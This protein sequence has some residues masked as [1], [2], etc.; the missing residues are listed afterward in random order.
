MKRLILTVLLISIS[1]TTNALALEVPSRPKGRISDYTKTLKTK[2]IQELEQTLARYE[3]ETTNQIAV[4]LIPTLAGDNLEDYSIRLAEKWKIGQKGKDNG[5]ILL[6]V[7]QDRKIRIEVG[8]GLE[9]ALPDSRAGEIIR[10]D[11]APY[12]RE[13]NFYKGIRVGILAII[14]VI[15]GEYGTTQHKTVNPSDVLPYFFFP[16]AVFLIPL[17]ILLYRRRSKHGMGESSHPTYKMLEP[18]RTP[19]DDTPPGVI[20]NL[21]F[22]QIVE[23]AILATL[24]DLANRG[25]IVIE[26]SCF[27]F[28]IVDYGKASSTLEREILAAI[29]ENDTTIDLRRMKRRIYECVRSLKKSFKEEAVRAGLRDESGEETEFGRQT[30]TKWLPFRMYL[31]QIRKLKDFE[32]VRSQW[33][34]YLPYVIAFGQDRVFFETVGKLGVPMPNWYQA[35]DATEEATQMVSKHYFKFWYLNFRSIMNTLWEHQ[36]AT[37]D[38]AYVGSYGKGGGVFGLGGGG[39]G[40]GGGGFGGGG[41]SGGW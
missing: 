26:H 14:E 39:F 38:G 35:S 34:R 18:S 12:F 28:H 7:K 1:L 24:I 2:E 3:R 33:A 5:V 16:L 19:P 11:I 27:T 21:L 17:F 25:A 29:F 41:A 40:G 32:E 37:G 22:R 10:K 20:A 15:G 4:V 6:I 36:M 23:R 9:G 31:G 30:A 13:G 8:Y